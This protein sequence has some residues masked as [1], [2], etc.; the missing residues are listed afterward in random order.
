[1]VR[2]RGGAP[3]SGVSFASFIHLS[4]LAYFTFLSKKE[5]ERKEETY[6][7]YKLVMIMPTFR[8]RDNAIGWSMKLCN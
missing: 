7:A 6:L 3:Q 8:H 5:M 2:L 4:T 1:M